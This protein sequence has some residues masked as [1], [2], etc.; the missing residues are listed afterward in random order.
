MAAEPEPILSIDLG[1][2]DTFTLPTVDDLSQWTE[3]YKARWEWVQ[4]FTSGNEPPVSQAA[5]E[6]W[7]FIRGAQKRQEQI[8]NSPTDVNV[9]TQLANHFKNSWQK[10]WQPEHSEQV[11]FVFQQKEEKG[12]RAGLMSLA[13]FL[14]INYQQAS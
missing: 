12:E 1:D 9:R 8:V 5:T 10:G 14:N 3:N 13:Y 7:N 11:E 4:K 6:I 2:E